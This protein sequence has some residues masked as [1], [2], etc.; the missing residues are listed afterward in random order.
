LAIILVAAAPAACGGGNGEGGAVTR[1]ETVTQKSQ[2]GYEGYSNAELKLADK[3]LAAQDTIISYCK[4][5]PGHPSAKEVIDATTLIVKAAKQNP[6]FDKE[7]RFA[8]GTARA[9][10]PGIGDQLLSLLQR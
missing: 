5:E 3:V 1:T 8:T 9:C 2:T 6:K 7:L 10:P 4:A